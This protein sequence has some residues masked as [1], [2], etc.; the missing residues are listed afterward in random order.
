MKYKTKSKRMQNYRK[1]HLGRCGAIEGM[2]LQ[3]LIMVIVA[4]IVLGIIGGWLFIL[5]DTDPTIDKIIVNPDEVTLRRAE[6]PSIKISVIDTD[7]N[8]VSGVVLLIEGCG[9]ELVEEL[10]SGEEEISLKGITLPYNR[11]TG[12]LSIIA[13]KSGMGTRTAEVLV[14]QTI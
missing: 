1:Q 14:F 10:D 2:P 7:G 3:L 12:Y 9:I 4:V 5:R 13:Q 6:V 11:P 8:L